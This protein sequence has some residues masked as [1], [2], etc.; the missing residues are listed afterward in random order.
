TSNWCDTVKNVNLQ[1]AVVS[2]TALKYDGL[3]RRIEKDTTLA[4][5]TDNRV[6]YVYDRN[7]ILF[8]YDIYGNRRAT[9]IGTGDTDSHLMMI[10]DGATYFYHTDNLGSVVA[11]TDATGRLENKITYSPFGS[12]LQVQDQSGSLRQPASL[13]TSVANP[14]Y[15]T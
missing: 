5:C 14:F 8:E 12:I 4:D 1:N 9:Y 6:D 3:G 15:F 11:M 10:R 2:Q 13:G 7:N